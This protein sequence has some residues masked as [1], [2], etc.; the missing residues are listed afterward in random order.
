MG[1]LPLSHDGNSKE[2]WVLIQYDEGPYEKRYIWTQRY[3]ENGK[4][5]VEIG[6][7]QLQGRNSKESN[8]HLKLEKRHRTSSPLEP[9]EGTD[10]PHILI[11]DFKTQEVLQNKF[12][13]F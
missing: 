11:L 3:K 2:E 9:S 6:V 13:L 5:E 10:T 1:L 7:M 4:M 8:H 12:L